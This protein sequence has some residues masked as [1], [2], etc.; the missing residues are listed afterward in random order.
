MKKL[1]LLITTI[2]GLISCEKNEVNIQNLNNNQITAL[3][4]AGMGIGNVLP[5]N[6]FESISRAIHTG[7]DGVEIDIQLSFDGEFVAY[8]DSHLED[9][10][11]KNG[12]FYQMYW[13]DIGRAKYK[14]PA[15]TNFK[16]SSLE[17]ILSGIPNVDHYVI[18]FDCK[19][20]NPDRSEEYINSYVEKLFRVITKYG[21][22]QNCIVEFKDERLAAKLKGKHPEIK[23]FFFAEFNKA[24]EVVQ[25]LDLNGINMDIS[26]ISKAQVDL[27]HQNGIMISVYNTHKKQRNKRAIELNV[28]INQTDRLA[29]FLRILD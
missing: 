18:S 11:N 6:S 20:F 1:I 27:A 13:K 23:Q 4:H 25:A 7:A 2:A 24:L 21:L 28:D 16:V 9:N 8:H 10:S 26:E 3:G 22:E 5:M 12:R 14:D 29:H 17:Q 15:L 19:L